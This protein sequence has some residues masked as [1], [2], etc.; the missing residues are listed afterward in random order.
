MSMM[1]G[2][3]SAFR[4]VLAAAVLLLAAA[5]GRT[6]LSDLE[7]GDKIVTPSITGVEAEKIKIVGSSTVSPF[8][9]AVAE[10]FG[11]VTKWPTPTHRP[12]ILSGGVDNRG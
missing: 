9:T 4:P 12:A 5:C 11:A 1:H 6:D 10:Q 8:A 7:V 3:P 2:R